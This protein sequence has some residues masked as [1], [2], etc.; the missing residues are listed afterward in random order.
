MN[1]TI[2]P[3]MPGRMMNPQRIHGI[4]HEIERGIGRLARVAL[5]TAFT[6]ASVPALAAGFDCN[7]ARLPD[8]K[9]I[10]ASRQLSELD[11][12]MTVRYETL[13]GLVAMGARGNMQDEQQAWLNV[14]KK[15][16]AN[17]ACLVA[18]YRH[19]I[20]MLKDEYAH[21]ASRGPF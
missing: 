9:A 8:E 10:C 6:L 18:A 20:Q 4:E 12:E 1:R 7:E 5:L 19:R 21:L 16:G 11:V 17:E 13:T 15:C 2:C 14:R 3:A